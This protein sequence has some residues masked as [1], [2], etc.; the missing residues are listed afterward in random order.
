[1][2]RSI[3][4][5]AGSHA[6]LWIPSVRAFQTH[7]FTLMSSDPAEFVIDARDGFTKEL[8]R[9]ALENPKTKRRAAIEGP[10]G[11][12]PSAN[13]FDKVLL[14]AGGSGITYT[15]ATA[16]DWVRKNKYSRDNKVLDFVWAIKSKGKGYIDAP[17]KGNANI[18]RR[19][20]DVV[21]TRAL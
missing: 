5:R 18:D 10:Y 9:L 12:L 17:L 4:A 13:D 19:S 6:F 16:L 20:P 1:M 11:N 3:K 8:H 14:V 15:L 2:R 21:R 7:P